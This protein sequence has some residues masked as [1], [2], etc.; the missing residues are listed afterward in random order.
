[1]LVYLEREFVPPP[2]RVFIDAVPTGPGPGGTIPSRAAR[3][4]RGPFT[5]ERLRHFVVPSVAMV[6]SR[7]QTLSKRAQAGSWGHR[8]LSVSGPSGSG[9]FGASHQTRQELV[10]NDRGIGHPSWRFWVLKTSPLH[11]T[12]LRSHRLPGGQLRVTLAWKSSHC[13]RGGVA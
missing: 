12:L 8:K 10:A 5:P 6:P 3:A 9:A 4:D 13:T 7:G 2:V 1:M 11:S